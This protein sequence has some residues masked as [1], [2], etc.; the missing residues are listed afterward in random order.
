L[1]PDCLNKPC[2]ARVFWQRQLQEESQLRTLENTTLIVR[3]RRHFRIFVVASLRQ[4][5]RYFVKKRNASLEQFRMKTSKFQDK[6]FCDMLKGEF[7]T[8]ARFSCST[9][10]DL[11]SAGKLLVD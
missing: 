9:G 2:E 1:A 3:W 4:S 5:K 10:K 6:S 8:Q 7:T 11:C